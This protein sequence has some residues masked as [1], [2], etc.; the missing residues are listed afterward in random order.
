MPESGV[1]VAGPS[2]GAAARVL[3]PDV[4]AFLAELH[5]EFDPRRRELLS[6]RA[7][8]QAEL[9]AG[10]LPDFLAGTA[11]V[12][13]AEWSVAPTPSDLDDRRV[14]ITGPS[15][16]KMMINALNSGARVFMADFE[17]ALSPTWENV[18]VGQANVMDAVRRTLSFD[19]PEGKRYR[20]DDELATLLIRPRGWHLVERHVTVDGEPVSA[21]LFDFG[22]WFFHNAAELLE[23]GSGPYL[24]V[25]KL[26]SHLEARLWNDVFLFAQERLGVPRGSVRAT[27]LIET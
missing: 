17:D 22:V 3:T 19:S 11:G 13:S 15:E 18:V 9:D 6:R 2:V 8:R 12:R 20:L 10:A 25:P 23:R 1:E 27:V 14:E 4:L 21:S 24:Y 16:R 26:E 5:G 7:E